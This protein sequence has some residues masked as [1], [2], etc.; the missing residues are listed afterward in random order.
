[1]R[2]KNIKILNKNFEK[3]SQKSDPAVPEISWLAN[4]LTEQEKKLGW[5]LIFDGNT[6][7]GW[8]GAN[9]KKFPEVGWEIQDGN[10]MVLASGGAES[11][12]GGDIVTREEFSS[13]ELELDYMITEGA[14][15]GIKLFVVEGLVDGPGSAIGLEY[16][17]LD[18]KNEATE[19]HSAGSLYDLIGAVN[20]SENRKKIRINGPGSWN[21]ARIVV[22]GKAVEHWLNNLKVV[23]YER[24]SPEFRELVAGSKF[25]I[26]PGFGEAE[27]GHNLLQE[28]GHQVA[29]RSVK[30]REL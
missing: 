15:S 26:Y 10:L 29:F 17:I 1:M 28:H 19:N 11:R 18:V 20:I 7:D 21:K 16:Q 13:F 12:K 23:E 4:E 6:T 3:Y 8:R 5:R 25:A 14:N 22:K 2:W 30:I 24:G 9:D 27:S